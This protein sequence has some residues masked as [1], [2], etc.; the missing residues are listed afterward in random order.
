MD[1]ENPKGKILVVDDMPSSIDIL[2]IALE[3]EGY[4]VFVA[5]SGEKAPTRAT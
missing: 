2:R 4:N 1:R 5:T 3:K